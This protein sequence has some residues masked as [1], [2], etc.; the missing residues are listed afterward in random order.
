MASNG[1]GQQSP[2]AQASR[3]SQPA[4][5]AAVRVPRMVIRSAILS[6]TSTSFVRRSLLQAGVDALAVPVPADL[7]QVGDLV[8]GEAEPLGG[9]DDPEQ[10]DRVR[11]VEPVPARA[12]LR[13]GEQPAALVVAQ[14]LDVHARRV[15]HLAPAQP[16]GSARVTR[17]AQGGLA[18][19]QPGR[20]ARRRR[21]AATST[22]NA[23]WP[24]STAATAKVK[25]EQHADSASASRCARSARPASP[26]SSSRRRC[27][28]VAR[29]SAPRW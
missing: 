4:S 10:G 21:P 27:R 26:A 1:I 23:T 25:N 14:R 22:S 12:A 3:S 11:R 29:S 24:A 16:P 8:E 7:E 5:R 2:Q 9:L 17:P 15:G 20:L 18:R 19:G 28:R 6:S 13:L